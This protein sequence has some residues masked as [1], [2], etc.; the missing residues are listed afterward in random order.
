MAR[1]TTLMTF[2]LNARYTYM[3]Y[4]GH[5]NTIHCTFH[6]KQVLKFNSKWL[7]LQNILNSLSTF[8]LAIGSTKLIC[9]HTPY[10][11]RGLMSG[12]VYGSMAVFTLTG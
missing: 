10:S 1:V 11:I 12:A 6:E 9:A 2:V 8:T 7:T 5:N 4:G 3:E